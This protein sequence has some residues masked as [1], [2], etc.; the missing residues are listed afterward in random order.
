[1]KRIRYAVL[2]ATLISG[3]GIGLASPEI[4][5]GVISDTMCG[6]QHML[7]ERPTRSASRNAS[8]A[9]PQYALV[10]GDKVYALSRPAWRLREVRGQGGS[11]QRGVR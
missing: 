7:P 1:M 10:G 6:K 8:E 11:R 2:A 9:R 3:S 4:V 5:E